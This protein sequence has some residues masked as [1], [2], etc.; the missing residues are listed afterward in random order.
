MRTS[1]E[2]I[3]A[4]EKE[5]Y[6]EA[7]AN[8]IREYY[9]AYFDILGYR[10]FFSKQQE[11]VPDFLLAIHKVVEQTGTYISL[12]N[13]SAIAGGIGKIKI[14][15]KTFS[16]NILLCMEVLN[17][18]IDQLRLFA[19]LMIVADIQR[20]FI[21]EFGLF[22]RG[23][24]LQGTLS[25]NDNY[26]FG[27]GLIDVVEMEKKALY[28]RI[29]VDEGIV[30]KFQ[31]NG[32]ITKEE[33]EAT[34]VIEEKIQKEKELSQQEQELHTRKLLNEYAFLALK[35]MLNQLVFKWFDNIY[36]LNY[37]CIIES[38]MFGNI[39]KVDFLQTIKSVSPSDYDLANT[40]AK[41]IN[42]VLLQ[43]KQKIEE[44][45]KKYGHN[46]DIGIEEIKEA[47]EREKILRKY[48]WVMTYHNIIC[49]AYKKLDYKIYTKCNCDTRF[50]KMII[51]LE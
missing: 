22:V 41:D 36:I 9:I 10:D 5:D 39:K 15:E 51:E 48:I 45:L 20:G 12:I 35:Q 2:N 42:S 19:F 30:Q 13:Q 37:L 49:D 40:P 23:G 43:H 31:N 26:I 14:Q 4:L 29:V 8:P 1:D 17:E 27:Q 44:Q 21:T 7:V 16:D 47:E 28:P 6:M 24:I 18:P 50:M 46:S 25:F 33:Q 38:D 11:K 32:F 34:K 3:C